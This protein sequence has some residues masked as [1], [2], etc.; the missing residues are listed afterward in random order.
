MYLTEGVDTAHAF[1]GV[2]SSCGFD[3]DFWPLRAKLD[4][5]D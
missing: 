4:S 5:F 1:E 2:V 3:C